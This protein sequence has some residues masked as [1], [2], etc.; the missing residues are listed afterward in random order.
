M[1]EQVVH[2]Y[3]PELFDLLVETIPRLVK[4]KQA[5]L[6]FFKGCG[7]P[8]SDYAEPQRVVRENRGSVNKFEI[9]RQ[10]LRVVNDFGDA[11][12]SQR[13]EILKRVSQWDDF[14]RSYEND[15]VLAEGYV[16]KIQK[17]I[18]VKDSF[19]R[20]NNERENIAAKERKQRE[21]T[22]LEAKRI[23][24]ERAQIRNR[25][26]ALFTMNDPHA[27]GI[28]FEGILNDLFRSYGLSLREAF[29]RYGNAGE[30]VVEQIDGVVEL[31][32][33]VY[34][35][36][37][38]WHSTPI[39]TDQVTPHMVRVFCRGAAR[40]ILI[41]ASGFTNPA[42]STV[43]DQLTKA[44]FILVELSELVFLLEQNGSLPDLLTDKVR[45]AIVDKNPLFKR[46]RVHG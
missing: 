1:N 46:E 8:V 6:D 7:L 38:K 13:R 43:R 41:S 37:M 26:A 44:P 5:V 2:H 21:Q 11:R 18:N 42:I 14:S 9:V 10:V 34:L 32:G 36:E 31:A 17:L 30:G 27:R 15:R 4:G 45:A 35:V 12:L 20:M 19:T 33:Q 23:A 28:Q 22:M 16:A 3:P 25:L 24:D 40:G 29:S 39:G